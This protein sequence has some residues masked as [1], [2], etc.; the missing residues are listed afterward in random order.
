MNEAAERFNRIY[1]EDAR[2]AEESSS[3]FNKPSELKKEQRK[4]ESK[5]EKLEKP[6]FQSRRKV[7]TR[8]KSL[9]GVRFD[10]RSRGEWLVAY[11]YC[12]LQKLRI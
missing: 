7:R 12:N 6:P 9:F 10:K 11:C 8:S 3:D 5:I 1:D 2:Q 4:L